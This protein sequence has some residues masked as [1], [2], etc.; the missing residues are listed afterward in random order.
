MS[1]QDYENKRK[2]FHELKLGHKSMEEHIQKFMEILRHVGYIKVERVEVQN[3]LGGIPLS[4]K[5]RI[6]F[7]NP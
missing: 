6:E 1:S 4:Y 7:T 3:F 5:D 2:E